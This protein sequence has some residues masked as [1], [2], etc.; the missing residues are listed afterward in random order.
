MCTARYSGA[1]A[2]AAN[3]TVSVEVNPSARRKG[4]WSTTMLRGQWASGL[5]A[6]LLQQSLALLAPLIMV[7]CAI[8]SSPA[9]AA[10]NYCMPLMKADPAEGS[11]VTIARRLAVANWL[12][13]AATL[14]LQ[15]TRWGISWNHEVVCRAG[16]R[17]V[18]VC[19]ATGHPCA[20][21]Q[22]PPDSFLR[23]RPGIV[24]AAIKL[25]SPAEAGPIGERP[26]HAHA[27]SQ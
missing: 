26:D 21:R 7:I 13:R 1:A 12:R 8:A 23:L 2:T 3:S 16:G 6:G 22:V 27:R 25:D 20:V 19:Q 11:T 15:Y 17:G 5:R 18:V 10:V 24:A 9:H 14:G 4:V